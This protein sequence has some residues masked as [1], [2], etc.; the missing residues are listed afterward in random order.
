MRI[1]K[2]SLFIVLLGFILALVVYPIMPENIS[3]HW[4]AKGQPDAI[5]P[6]F[7]ALFP[8][9]ILSL[10]LILVFNY[11]PKLDP[12][13][14]N[15]KSFSQYYNGFILVMTIFLFYLNILIILSNLEISFKFNMLS[16]ILPAFA[17]LFFYIGILVKHAKRNWF[18]GIRTPWTLSSEKVWHQTHQVGGILFQVSAILAL[19][20]IIFPDYSVWFILVPVLTSSVFIVVYSYFIFKKLH[21]KN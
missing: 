5:T 16:A 10:V 12:L 21:L 19:L 14:L 4:N 8:I 6:K 2:I 11:L 17:L 15:Y 18:V 1:I 20:G 3:S 13:K 9:P 7:W